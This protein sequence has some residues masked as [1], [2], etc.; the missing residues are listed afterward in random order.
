MTRK[1]KIT[2]FIFSILII[3]GYF[4]GGY[5]GGLLSGAGLATLCLYLV[6]KKVAAKAIARIDKR[7]KDIL[8]DEQ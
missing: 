2:C 8:I 5:S 4:I 1:D 3:A 6:G 7:V